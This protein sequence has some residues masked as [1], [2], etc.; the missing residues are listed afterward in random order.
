MIVEIIYI[1]TK[2]GNSESMSEISENIYR[3]SFT[4]IF[5]IL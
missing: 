2:Q 3:D 5:M 4:M 1:E